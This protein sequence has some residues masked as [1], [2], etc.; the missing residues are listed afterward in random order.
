[1]AHFTRHI[2]RRGL[3]L[4]AGSLV[5]GSVH[6]QG[7]HIRQDFEDMPVGGPPLGFALGFTGGGPP[8]RWVVLDDP[9]APAGPRVLA[10]T[11]RDRTDTRFPHAVLDGFEARDVAAAVRFRPVDGRV[12]QAAGLVVRYRDARNYY[13]ARANALENNV[14]L[15]RVV[16]GRRIQFAGTDARV[17][18][19]RW[20]ALGLM[21]RGDRFEISLDGRMLFA[22]ADRTFTGA[23]R[24]GVWTKADSLTHFDALEAEEVP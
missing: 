15:Y 2:G 13:V 11:S 19:D 10:E 24:V 23:G 8:P 6:A 17:P 18:R 16:D 1:M 9:S 21:V 14:R 4:A 22:A 3:L 7:R 12:D 20:Q 5:A